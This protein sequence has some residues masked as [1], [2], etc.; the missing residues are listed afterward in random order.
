DL[1]LGGSSPAPRPWRALNVASETI[2]RRAGHR[3]APLGLAVL[4]LFGEGHHVGVACLDQLQRVDGHDLEQRVAVGTLD[5][6]AD[7]Q[8]VHVD[9]TTTGGACRR[10]GVCHLIPPRGPLAAASGRP[11]R[12]PRRAPCPR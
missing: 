3:E 6:R 5:R 11:A 9:E 10:Y 4:L 8:L 2:R 7:G 12:G 1:H